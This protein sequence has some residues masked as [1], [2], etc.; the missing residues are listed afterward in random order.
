MFNNNKI[1][2]RRGHTFT[3][4]RCE[5][6]AS[7]PLAVLLPYWNHQFAFVTWKLCDC[8]KRRRSSGQGV[9]SP[10]GQSDNAGG[11]GG[12]GQI[13][14]SKVEIMDTK[15]LFPKVDIPKV[16]VY[17]YSKTGCANFEF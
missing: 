15:C 13:R 5:A 12:G 9:H 6:K 10:Q 4:L 7:V 2:Q 11:G 1:A 14:G 17:V 3:H 16:N 8:P